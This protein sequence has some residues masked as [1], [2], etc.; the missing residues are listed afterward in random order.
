MKKILTILLILALI[1]CTVGCAGNTKT[2]NIGFMDATCIVV[3]EETGVNYI[4][5]KNGYGG[6]LAPRYNPDGT[7]YISEVE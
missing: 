4:F 7:L 2:Q 6:G 5:Y 1:L 3:D